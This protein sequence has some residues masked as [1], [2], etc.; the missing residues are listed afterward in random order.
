MQVPEWTA[1]KTDADVVEG[2]DEV[3]TGEKGHWAD[4][5]FDAESVEFVDD[6]HFGG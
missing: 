1:D 5:T 6:C 3:E 2:V 4:D